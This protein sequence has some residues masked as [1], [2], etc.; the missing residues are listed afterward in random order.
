V[1]IAACVSGCGTAR[2]ALVL[3]PG[4]AISLRDGLAIAPLGAPRALTDGRR[5]A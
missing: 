4:L 3:H 2:A 1:V 5:Q